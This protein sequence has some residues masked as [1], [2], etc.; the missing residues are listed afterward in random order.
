MNR[1]VLSKYDVM[2]VAEGAGVGAADA[3]DYVDADR[4][5]L[6]MLYHFE[7]VARWGRPARQ[8]EGTRTA[9]TQPGRVQERSTPSGTASSRTTGWGTV[10]LG[11]HDQRRMT[12][13]WGN[14]AAQW[15]DHLVQDADHVPAHHA[16][17]A[18]HLRRR[19]AVHDQ[20]QVRPRSR[21]TGTSMTINYYHRL[22]REGGDL[23]EFLDRA[24]GTEAGTKR[25][26]RPFQ[27]SADSNAGFTTG[28]P[29]IRVNP[30]YRTVN[31]AAEERDRESVLQ[32]FR[33]MIRLR[34]AEPVLVYGRYQLLD[35]E[36]PELFAY[37]RTLDGRTLMVALSFGHPRAG[38]PRLPPGY[39]AGAG[40]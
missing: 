18:V 23:R 36:N 6:D 9:A 12:T 19:R 7:G 25:A 32:Y 13:R 2:S 11:N 20:H 24:G 5:E 33:R 16:R 3:L 38:A 39:R 29:W 15:R 35:R 22:E 37:T 31:V 21:I 14:D 8:P 28:A 4:R 34:K 40:S 26:R 30:D 1:E 27:W 10:Y 17:D